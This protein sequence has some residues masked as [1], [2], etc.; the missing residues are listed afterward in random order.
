LPAASKRDTALLVVPLRK[1]HAMQFLSDKRYFRRLK[2]IEATQ[3]R[4]NLVC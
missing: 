2:R 3:P 4:Y 1:P